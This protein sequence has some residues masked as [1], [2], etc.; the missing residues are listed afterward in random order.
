[1][2]KHFKVKV[3]DNGNTNMKPNTELDVIMYKDKVIISSASVRECTCDGALPVGECDE[4]GRMAQLSRGT[5][6]SC[7]LQRCVN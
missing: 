1:M 4:C 7:M 3:I 6:P 2:F 5:C